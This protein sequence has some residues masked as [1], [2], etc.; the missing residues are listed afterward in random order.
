MNSKK[1]AIVHEKIAGSIGGSE[2]ILFNA[3]NLFPDA[4]VYSIVLD[5]KILPSKYND[6]KINTTFIQKLPFSRKKYK[7]YFPLMPLAVE[8]LNLQ[9]FDVIFS[10]HHCVAKGIIPRPDAVH[11]C[12]CHS[13]ARYIWDLF[14]TYSNLNRF[15][16][17]QNFVISAISQYIRTW[18]VVS[19]NRIDYFLANSSYTAARIKKFYNRNSEILYPPVETSKFKHATSDDYYLMVGRLVS[20]KGFELAIRAFNESGKNLVIIGDGPEFVKY[21]NLAGAN[22][23][24]IGHTS[25]E[26]LIKYMNNCKGYIFP[27]REDFGIVMAE[28]QAAGKPVIAYE[29]GGALDIVIENETGLFF[30]EQTISSLN[31][32]INKSESFKWDHSFIMQ[33]S[34]KFDTK[35]FQSRLKYILENAEKFKNNV[36]YCNLEN[37]EYCPI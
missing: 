6:R 29:E 30:K 32:A 14:W 5:L 24:M 16:A 28:A 4:A 22:I 9:E 25:E 1:L 8:N 26:V 21:K 35:N 13:P 37:Y 15:N 2:Y 36:E 10:S 12:Y 27:G 17:F 18:D 33:H 20:Y 11:I 19:S 31:Q 7:A 23:K 34:K 3:M